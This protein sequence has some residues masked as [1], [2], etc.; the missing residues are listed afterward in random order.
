MI[1]SFCSDV[2]SAQRLDCSALCSRML[3]AASQELPAPVPK[4]WLRMLTV[5]KPRRGGGG[6][7]TRTT[8]H[9]W[10]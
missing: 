7:A 5:H 8:I 9:M 10:L 3:H 2:L 4:A 6:G 1:G